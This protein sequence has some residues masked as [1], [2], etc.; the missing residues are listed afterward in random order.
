MREAITICV[1]LLALLGPFASVLYMLLP[2]EAW[3]NHRQ[4]RH[5]KINPSGFAQEQLLEHPLALQYHGL[6]RD[7][8]D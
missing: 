7:A 4:R 3:A 8:N 6:V 5:V 2:E 1:S